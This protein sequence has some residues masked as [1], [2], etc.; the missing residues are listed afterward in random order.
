MLIYDADGKSVAQIDQSLLLISSSGPGQIHQICQS[1]YLCGRLL[2]GTRF[3]FSDRHRD[4]IGRFFIRA[5]FPGGLPRPELDDILH[6]RLRGLVL[7][8]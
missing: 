4:D 5:A 1:G 7:P 6:R 2:T 8:A 3:T